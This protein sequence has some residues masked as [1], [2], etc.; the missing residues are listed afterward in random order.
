VWLKLD[1]DSTRKPATLRA[2]WV[3]MDGIE[4]WS[5]EVDE[6]DLTAPQ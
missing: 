3:Q 4:M 5:L 1:V 2:E 6:S